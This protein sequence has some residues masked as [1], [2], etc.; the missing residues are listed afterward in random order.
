MPVPGRGRWNRAQPAVEREKE[1]RGVILLAAARA[2]SQ[3][4]ASVRVEDI[5]FAA[6]VGRNTF[7]R[8][9]HDPHAAVAEA[10]L[11][12][13][14]S[15]EDRI[16]DTTHAARTPRDRLR[17]LAAAWFHELRRQG[18]FAAA[19]F[20]P[21]T[22]HDPLERVRRSLGEVLTDVLE[23]A[24]RAGVVG[25]RV[26]PSRLA[27]SVGAFET[28]ARLSLSGTVSERE[29]EETLTDVVLRSFR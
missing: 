27:L 17:E 6:G 12:A 29:L 9:F 23:E 15:L 16:R 2:A 20:A 22:A 13:A 3:A 24:R 26:D 19:L 10:R 7:Y 14:R 8:F 18:A 5:T 11:A 21:G 4:R 1:L 25:H 28:A